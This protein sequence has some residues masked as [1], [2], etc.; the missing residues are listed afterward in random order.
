MPEIPLKLN[1]SYS[2]PFVNLYC[3]F[4]FVPCSQLLISDYNPKNILVSSLLDFM[5]PMK[6]C[7][8]GKFQK[9]W[10]ILQVVLI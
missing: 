10:W 5:A 3:M 1:M 6:I 2:L 7:R 4:S 9:P 8:L